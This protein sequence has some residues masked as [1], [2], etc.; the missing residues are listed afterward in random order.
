MIFVPKFENALVVP[1]VIT[2][3]A[4]WAGHTPFAMWLISILKPKLLVEL[5]TYSG[6]SY[7]SFCQ[8][9]LKEGL[10]T[11]CFAVDTWEGDHHAGYYGEY[12]YQ[13]LKSNHD[14]QYSS[15]S[16][17]LRKTFDAAVQDFADGSIDLLHIDGLHTYE[18]VKH[19]FETW[20]SKLSSNAV[21]M[22][23]DINVYENDFGVHKFWNEI[24]DQFPS[25]SFSHSNGLGV[26]FF[27]S[28]S[29][30]KINQ[31]GID[32][33]ELDVNIPF[34]LFFSALGAAQERRGELHGIQYQLSESERKRQD[35]SFKLQSTES[36]LQ[37]VQSDLAEI[38]QSFFLLKESNLELKEAVFKLQ[39][40]ISLERDATVGLQYAL[41]VIEKS[42]ENLKQVSAQQHNWI[43]SQD[44]KIIA[45]ECQLALS[46]QSIRGL[47]DELVS[48]F[49][50]KLALIKFK[51]GTQFGI[52]TNLKRARRFFGRT[53][54]TMRYI[55]RG[56][57]VGLMQRIVG[58]RKNTS[59]VHDFL[60]DNVTV[61]II[62]TPHTFFLAT[63]IQRVLTRAGLSSQ[64][65]SD[66]DVSEF[67]AKLYIVI[68]AQM[69]N[70]LPPGER[71]IVFQMEQ[72]VSERWFDNRY[73]SIL[74]NSL[75]V[76]DYSAANLEY[77]ASRGLVY[78]HV[79]HVPL[80]ANVET[81]HSSIAASLQ[82]V[83]KTI[84]VLFYGDPHSERRQKF[85]TH[86]K[87]I[88]NVVVVGNL[89][90]YELRQ[91]IAS[92]KV[93]IN[94]H[95]Y[96]NAL[97]ESTRI[98]ECLSLGAHVISETAAD[99][100]DY[101]GLD[102]AVDFVPVG[103]IAVMAERVAHAL[104]KLPLEFSSATCT[105]LHQTQ[106]RFQFMLLRG[107]LA[108]DVISYS[109]FLASTTYPMHEIMALSLPE[110]L[111]RRM[112]WLANSLP[113]SQVF[114]GLRAR[115]GWIGCALSYKYICTKALEQGLNR[116]LVC[117]DD[118]EW[119]ADYEYFYNIIDKFLIKN[120]GKW[121]IFVGIISNLHADAEVIE[122]EEYDGL[123]FVTLDKM[124]SMVFNI[125]SPKAMRL[126]ANWNDTWKDDQLNTI[127]RYLESV[128]GLRVVTL[129]EPLFGHREDQSSTL[130]GFQNTQYN[131]LIDES[132]ALLGKKVADFLG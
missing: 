43:V 116:I 3:P 79:F 15:F 61:G 112:A 128:P 45:L 8:I 21:V 88:F 86:L 13:T 24:K 97:L 5:G 100:A 132:R 78:P 20:R 69:F 81:D 63:A 107:L 57:F 117:E 118:A 93:V 126:I 19:D 115:P 37:M 113:G 76:F 125:Y 59:L 89:F 95:Y 47:Q 39:Q 33:I 27:G 26:L 6:I 75:A 94:I 34:K 119:P 56:D 49:D 52:R 96:E 22:F 2:S 32:I 48:T 1:Q 72:T 62:S 67:S 84:D 101:P 90:G 58:E 127:D 131:S 16:T 111:N 10:L 40:Q 66:C 29:A 102:A 99:V 23:H 83:P 44:Q 17:L 73:I 71:R 85:L 30:K 130:W 7:L 12:I 114:D 91:K 74:E 36:S 55:Q 46:V 25:C 104:N 42:H 122:V 9:V 103:D 105:Y 14:Y 64:I 106:N 35:M 92:A 51:I 120:E 31:L 53:K 68:C 108:L 38:Q 110:T 77:L 82:A 18:A 11:R 87:S 60:T 28:D 98:F 80:G 109:N 121:D 41:N 124:T 50:H 70:N 4:P 129:L 123:T 54:N 65:I